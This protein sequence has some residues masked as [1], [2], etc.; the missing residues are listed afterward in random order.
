M[1]IQEGVKEDAYAYRHIYNSEAYHSTNNAVLQ[2]ALNITG[3]AKASVPSGEFPANPTV[4]GLRITV[5]GNIVIN[6]RSMHSRVDTGGFYGV[7]D[8]DNS[9]VVEHRA[10]N[11]VDNVDL[12]ISYIVN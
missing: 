3:R 12:I 7:F 2:T 4:H 8:F 6:D 1:S 10:A 11:G 9:L 5:D